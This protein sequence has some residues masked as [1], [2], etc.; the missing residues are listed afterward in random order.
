MIPPE[1]IEEVKNRA[2]IVQ[3]LSEYIPGMRKAGSNYKALSPFSNEKTPSFIVSP[4]KQIFKDFSSGRGGS[5]F[6]FLQEYLNIN[7]PEAVELV[8]DKV[9]VKIP[10]NNSSKFEISDSEQ[11]RRIMENLADFYHKNLFANDST[12]L[13]YSEKRGFS[14]EVISVYC[15]GYS[16]NDWNTTYNHLK[17]NNFQDETL[18]K[19][20]LIKKTKRGSW[21]DYYK[22]RLI[23]PIR[24]KLGRTVGFGGRLLEKSDKAPKYLNTPQTELYDKSNILYGLFEAKEEIRNK[25]YA[26][27]VEGYAD[28]VG[29]Y[30]KGI[31]NAIASSGTAL[32]DGQVS[33]LKNYTN[34]VYLIYDADKAGINAAERGLEIALKY[35]F[36]I[37][38]IILPDGEDPDSLVLKNGANYFLN[39]LKSALDFIEFKKWVYKWRFGDLEFD[40]RANLIRDIIGLILKIPD[41]LKHSHYAGRAEHVLELNQSESEFVLSQLKKSNNSLK[42]QNDTKQLKPESLISSLLDSEVYILDT[43]VNNFSEK[44]DLITKFN[45]GSDIFINEDAGFVFDLINEIPKDENLF[46]YLERNDEVSQRDK[47][48]ILSLSLKDEDVN[49]NLAD[50]NSIKDDKSKLIRL[51]LLNLKKTKLEV[52]HKSLTKQLSSESNSKI[53]M[54][55]SEIPTEIEQINEKLRD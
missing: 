20:G 13:D 29:L 22:G 52:E 42:F 37:K 40:Q 27:L 32:T 49:K 9:G 2:D 14:E 5:V 38:I 24:N 41:R 28:V 25:D 50:K 30:A 55:L 48:I 34:K 43:L 31:R 1:I 4:D 54:R 23:F 7:F 6:T 12:A 35:D 47:E 17:K 45:L 44:D 53:L 11:K 51:S 8:A 33:L 19:L 10:K 16:P 46:S 18:E 36:N 15:I 3:I 39:F 21:Y 26:I